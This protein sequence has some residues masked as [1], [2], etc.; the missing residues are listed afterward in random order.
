[1]SRLRHYFAP[2]LLP[3]LLV[4]V[5]AQ[6]RF[7]PEII[8]DAGHPQCRQ[9]QAMALRAF[10]STSPSL[11]WPIDPPTGNRITLGQKV[12]EISG[13]D[14]LTADPAEFRRIEGADHLF[15]IYWQQEPRFG[16]RIAVVDRRRGWRGDW[17]TVHMLAPHVTM[18][19]LRRQ[20]SNVDLFDSDGWGTFQPVLGDNRWL[21]PLFLEHTVSGIHWFIDR[22]NSWDVQA[23]WIVYTIE[24]KGLSSPC[25][26]RFASPKGLARLPSAVRRLAAELDEALGPGTDEG[27]LRPTGRIRGAVEDDWATAATRPWALTDQPYNSRAQINAGL[28]TWASQSATRDRLHRS[29]LRDYPAA[30]RA[31]AQYYVRHFG[32]QGGEVDKFSRYAADHLLRTYF[33]FPRE[34]TPMV[35]EDFPPEERSVNPWPR[36]VR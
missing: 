21:P 18:E 7:D 5:P 14:A 2:L 33:V 9:A 22:G 27:T 12:E 28:A 16:R 17:Y 20:V 10:R 32:I 19:Q 36:T 23:D 13:G 29:I 30:V 24:A 11:L 34:D 35:L 4:G 6:A 25:R 26:V 15:I 31:L 3:L 8:G 1:M